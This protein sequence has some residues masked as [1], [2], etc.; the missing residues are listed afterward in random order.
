MKETR[1]PAG[2]VIL[3]ISDGR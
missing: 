1:T 3:S 2:A